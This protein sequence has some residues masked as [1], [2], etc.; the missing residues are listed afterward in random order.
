[1][2]D[3]ALIVEDHVARAFGILSNARMVTSSEALNLLSTL[4]LG[5]DLGM[6]DEFSRRD[7]DMLFIAIQPA[8]LQKFEGTDLGAEERDAVRAGMLRDFMKNALKNKR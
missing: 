7:V 6:I 1:M 2:N 4:R 8:H 5:L 3:R